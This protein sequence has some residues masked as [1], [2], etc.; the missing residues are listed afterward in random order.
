MATEAEVWRE[1]SGKERDKAIDALPFEP[2]NGG[3]GCL[4][5]CTISSGSTRVALVG[6]GDTLCINNV[7]A[8]WAHL[9]FGNSSITATTACFGVPPDTQLLILAPGDPEYVAGITP[10]G[11][12]NIQISRGVG[13]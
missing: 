11:S 2:S 3:I 12:T 8:A 7:G 4:V 5:A 1:K 13:N 6:Y 9:V 10:S